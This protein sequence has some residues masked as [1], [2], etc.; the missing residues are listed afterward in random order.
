MNKPL[1]K[2]GHAERAVYELIQTQAHTPAVITALYRREVLALARAG[3]LERAPDGT[4][5]Q[6]TPAASRPASVPPPSKSVP[7]P[8]PPWRNLNT[9]CP[10]EVFESIALL[11][12]GD[13]TGKRSDIVR[14]ALARGLR[15]MIEERTRPERTKSGTR[16]AV[17]PAEN[18][19]GHV[20]TETDRDGTRG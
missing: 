3:L 14:E 6:P 9:R 11:A 19:N 20:A 16:R 12:G 10:E 1:P 7:P 15:I 17:T 5:I 4:F 18:T 13:D 2:L 8:A